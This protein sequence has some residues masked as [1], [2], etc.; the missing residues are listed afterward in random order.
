VYAS[1]VNSGQLD[2]PKIT[3]KKR[4]TNYKDVGGSKAYRHGILRFFSLHKLHLDCNISGRPLAV[5]EVQRF[6]I[7]IQQISVKKKLSDISTINA[8]NGTCM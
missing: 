1:G 3:W 6:W 7:H 2:L 4:V 5:G 8:L